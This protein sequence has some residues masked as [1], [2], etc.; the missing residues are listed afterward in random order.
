[1]SLAA[2][3]ARAPRI[4]ILAAMSLALTLGG[5]NL[6]NMHSLSAA[7]PG[8]A[9][10]LADPRGVT[11]PAEDSIESA[12]EQYRERNFGLAEQ[13]F[14]AIVEKDSAN[15]EAWLGLAASYDQLRRF[16]HADRAY[17]Q[18]IKL[19][20]ASAALHNNMGYSYLLR[21]NRV[22]AR[23][24]FARARALDPN[25]AFIENNMRAAARG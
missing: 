21:G 18:V 8:E 1:M 15:A 12:K 4:N 16:D 23:A 17:A 2:F 13:K 7:P 22:R 6:G 25:N 11:G 3:G 24:E 14:R 20:G 9:Q 10:A 5:C 19:V